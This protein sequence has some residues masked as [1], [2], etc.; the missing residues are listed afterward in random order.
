VRR[1]VIMA[2]LAAALLVV[3]C[4]DG[5]RE[6]K[7]PLE[8]VPQADLRAKLRSAV[9]PRA[10]DFPAATGK[11]LQQVADEAGGSGPEVALATTALTPG[12]NRL[13]FG[14]IDERGEFLY[15]KTAVYVAPTPDARA[16]GPYPAPADP[17]I[18]DPPYRSRQAA[19]ESDPFAAVY[20]AE[21]P[22]PRRGTWSVLVV[23]RQGSGMVAAPAQVEVGG[24]AAA[25]IPAVGERPPRVE[26]D[27]LASAKGDVEKI[28]TRVPPSRMHEESFAD[29]LGTKPVAL[30][31][32]T[33]QLCQSRVCG[34][35]T[36]IAAQM[37][38]EYGDRMEFIHQEVY[39]DNDPAK[40][41]REPLRRFSLR[42]EPWL[43]VV[44]ANGRITAR[45]EGS[46]GLKAFE[47]AIHTAL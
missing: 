24:K 32:S 5:G 17:L 39:V 30:L 40:G 2:I 33:P 36:D 8:Q 31:F 46:F 41:L 29:V 23:T 16:R 42:T 13:A 18:T 19:T 14:V 28:D 47:R 4:G 21:V 45:M 6:S 34:P 44:D 27:T 43:F 37:Q 7:D 25:G 3:G 11:S 10:A 15:G 9:E 38:A 12:R 20:A 35:V 1:N 26:T 22:F